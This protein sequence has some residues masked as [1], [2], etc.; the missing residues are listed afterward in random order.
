MSSPEQ[1][2]S[3]LLVDRALRLAMAFAGI[4]AAKQADS[5]SMLSVDKERRD[6]VD[7]M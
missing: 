6:E 4:F 7:A 2:S 1:K 5:V 3:Y